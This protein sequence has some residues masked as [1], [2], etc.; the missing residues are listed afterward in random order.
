MNG[1]VLVV[2]LGNALRGDDAAGLEVAARLAGDP[3]HDCTVRAFEGEPIGLLDA[4]AGAAGV[5]VVDAVRSGAPAGT[6]HRIAAVAGDGPP[7]VPDAPTSSH[8]VGLGEVLAL[9][10]ELGRLPP[11]LVVLGVAGDCFDTGAP[12]SDAVAAALEPLTAAA[13]REVE[14]LSAP[15]AS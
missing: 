9:A 4:W 7:A 3:P 10:H 14:A 12:L 6:I 2:G 5:V 13:R 8:A 15:G 11:V 1:G